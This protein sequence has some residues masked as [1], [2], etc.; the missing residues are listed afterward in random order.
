M[1]RAKYLIKNSLIF[2]LG[3]LGTKII[4]FLLVPL[5]TNVLLPSEY[6]IADLVFTLGT[7]LVPIFIF[8][9]NESILRF[10]L[11]KNVDSNK[12]MSVGLLAIVAMV[13]ISF[14]AYPLIRMY[15]AI[16]DYS[17]YVILYIVSTGCNTIFM[18]NLRGK[19][20]L[21][22]FSVGNII[23]ACTVAL[24]NILLLKVLRLGLEGYFFA[25][26][27]A[28]VVT[29]LYAFGAGNVITTIRNFSIDKKLMLSMLKYSVVLIPNSFMWWILDSSNRVMLTAISG[30][31][32]TGMYAVAG[33]IPSLVSVVS[34]IFNQAWNY[35]AIKESDSSDRLAYN[36]KIFDYLFCTVVM[37]ASCILLILKPFVSIYVEASYY[38]SWKYTPPLVLG[39]VVLV[40]STFLSSTYTVAKDSKGFLLSATVGAISNIALNFVLIPP[41]GAFGAAVSSCLGYTT[42]FLYRFFDTKRYLTL[43]VF[44][45][46]HII[47]IICLLVAVIAIY[48]GNIGYAIIIVELVVLLLVSRENI[49]EIINLAKGMLAKH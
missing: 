25:Y 15:D 34:S 27:V 5:Y 42:V 29:M 16:S 33:K 18:Y 19:E 7:F 22:R 24:M 1:S 31:A 17:L 6:G 35:S 9:I 46:K 10:S 39:A 37:I 30:A 11:D 8:N 44:T 45:S 26:I 12:I 47:Q 13:C 36:N 4:N 20:F 23:N 43:S 3:T 48:F 28:N 49:S 32:V 21:V 40:L 14:F 38:E 2:A 41:L